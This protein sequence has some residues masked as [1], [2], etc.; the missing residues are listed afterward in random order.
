[1]NTIFLFPKKDT[2][3]KQTDYFSIV[4]NDRTWSFV[5]FQ[6]AAAAM[7]GGTIIS[8]TVAISTAFNSNSSTLAYSASLSAAICGVAFLNYT[9]M[10]STRL[11]TIKQCLLET[12]STAECPAASSPVE[13][14]DGF[15]IT[16]LRYSDW[17][18]TFPLL[19][20]K[21]FHLACDGPK[22]VVHDVLAST[23]IQAIVAGLG[24]LMIAFGFLA[25]IA[26][27]DFE[28]VRTDSTRTA[29]IRWTLYLLG[30]ACLVFEYLILFQAV[31]ETESVHAREV[32][33]F[34]LVWALYPAVFFLQAFQC[35]RN[36][37]KDVA[38][39]LLDV[40]SKPLLA[41]Y[42]AQAALKAAE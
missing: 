22:P 5:I 19:A 25:L 27:G 1:M 39:A 23:Y 37:H 35:L 30:T 4:V 21:L 42:I 16:T 3:S 7:L 20:L 9:A 28:A 12:A 29:F 24:F 26:T 41:V 10:T 38:F 18:V 17:V 40:I 31:H 33:G 6:A 34:S 11:R 13:E 32:I 8:T 15:V 2:V 14:I 36:T